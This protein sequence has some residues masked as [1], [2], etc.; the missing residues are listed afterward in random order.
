MVTQVRHE[1]IQC[2][3]PGSKVDPKDDEAEVP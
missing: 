2:C 1:H 3:I